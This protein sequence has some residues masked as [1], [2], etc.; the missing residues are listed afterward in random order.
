MRCRNATQTSV[1]LEW[2]TIQLATAEL[3]SLT[4]FRNGNK[5]GNIPR[6]FETTSTKISGLALDTQYA[7]TLVLRTSAGTY[8]SEKLSVRTHKM[9][10]LSGIT[11]TPGFMA[12]ALRESLESTVEQMGAKLVESV[13]IDTTHFVCTEGR[14]AAWEKANEMNVPVVQPD[15]LKGCA[16]EGRLVGVRGY[17]LGADPKA[18]QV[19][20]GVGLQRENS[21]LSTQQSLQSPR[22]G[23][24]PRTPQITP[25]TP[26]TA[27]HTA[28]V[29]EGDEN[30]V[31][32]GERQV[33]QREDDKDE[34]AVDDKASEVE[35]EG[36]TGEVPDRTRTHE[37]AEAIAAR[38]LSQPAEILDEGEGTA[39]E[40]VTEK[41]FDDVQL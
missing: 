15:W 17:Y 4:L 30:G 7:F 20:P 14:G 26:E 33:E 35:S 34:E 13:R 19:G 11:V 29:E 37:E 24:T 36:T 10:D 21:Q 3:R 8:S 40:A 18:R 31:E 12:P 22:S 9:T 32:D 27:R 2:D 41:E 28:A 39:D 25:P 38:V 5:A 1:V 23:D 6:P 16:R